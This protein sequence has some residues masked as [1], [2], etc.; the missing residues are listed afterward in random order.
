[1]VEL[2]RWQTDDGPVVVEVDPDDA[3][4]Q[5][6]TRKSGEIVDMAERF[7]NILAP[8]RT[9]AMATLRTFRDRALD[10]HEISLVFGVKITVEAGAIIAR[11]ALD[12]HISVT[13]KW[14]HQP[15]PGGE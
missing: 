10:A 11:T 1:M 3:G 2:A 5:G 4:F 12:G 13:V 9:A 8:V 15:L 6:V 7:E 14:Q